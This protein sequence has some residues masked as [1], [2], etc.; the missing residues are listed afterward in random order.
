LRAFVGLRSLRGRCIYKVDIKERTVPKLTANVARWGNSLALR[1]PKAVA[2][3]SGLTDG[4]AVELEARSGTITIRRAG[5]RLE[6]LLA[7]VT[8]ENCHHEV[9][10]GRPIGNEL[11]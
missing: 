7:R 5:L 4:T 8:P 11:L 6:E 10:W 1:L 2:R 9:D 3:Q